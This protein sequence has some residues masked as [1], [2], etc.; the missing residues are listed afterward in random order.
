MMQR[1]L[2]VLSVLFGAMTMN[3]AAQSRPLP[4]T[5]SG[6]EA[7]AQSAATLPVQGTILYSFGSTA[8][9]GQNPVASLIQA[10]DGNFYGVTENGGV[11]Y[12]GY[13]NGAIVQI[14]PA[15]QETVVYSFMGTTDGYYPTS[16]LVQASDGNLYGTTEGGGNSDS[17]GGGTIYQYNLIDTSMLSVYLRKAFAMCS[18]QE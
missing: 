6:L 11:P 16:P 8:S 13:A 12:E 3:L 7:H 1:F 9:D 14:T 5:A 17:S 18:R 2:L 15:G 10:S 4:V